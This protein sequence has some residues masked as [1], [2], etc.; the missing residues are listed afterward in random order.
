MQRGNWFRLALA[1]RDWDAALKQA[2]AN[3]KDKSATSYMRA[4][5]YLA[6]GDLERAR[7]EVH[8][9]QEA[10]QT[11]RS[12]KEL[13]LRLWTTHGLLQCA[14]GEPDG[15]LKLL[16][17]LVDK[18]KDD[19]NKHAWGHGS[20]PMES[21]G[22]GTCGPTDWRTRKKRSWKRWP[23]IRAPCRRPSA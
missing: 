9:L 11:G 16:A 21:W 15:G 10:Y 19:Y 2:A 4:L 20:E 18:T 23:T 6:K 13:E 22:I 12:N 8:V 14:A 5:V 3:T 7:P 1:E 17:K